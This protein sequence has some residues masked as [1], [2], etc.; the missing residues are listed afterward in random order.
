MAGLIGNGVTLQGLVPQ[1]FL[2]TWNISGTVD[3]STDIGKAVSIDAT[4][5]NTAKLCADDAVI[6]GILASYED[7]KQEGIKVGAVAHKGFFKV[8]Y[9]N[10]A[11]DL[12]PVVGHSVK[13]SATA[14]KVKPVAA[15]DGPNMVVEVDTTNGYVV[16]MIK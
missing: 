16:L 13:G 6:L 3:R 10:G 12:V 14:G 15:Y 5:A 4:A 2:A 9:V 8:P 1:D 7:R 11:T